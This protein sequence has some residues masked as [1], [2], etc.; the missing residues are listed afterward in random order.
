MLG[1]G[2]LILGAGA[3]LL[4][5]FL[6]VGYALPGTWE[7]RADTIL[8]VS[9]E[10]V[11][12]LLDSPEGWR[13]WTTWP[14][15]GLVRSGPERGGGASVS[16]DDRELGSGTFTVEDVEAA[17]S[18]TYSVEVAGVGGSAMRTSGRISLERVPDGTRV[19]WQERG[20]LGSNPLMG[21]WAR[22]MRRAQSTEM[23][24]G[25][26]RLGAAAAAGKPAAESRGATDSI[27]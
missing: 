5:G 13:A 12:P 19:A 8:T 6:A 27:R 10:E 7:A 9:P 22:S 3:V 2:T 26:A 25:L 20:D 14:D 21:W 24:K 23:A 15:S 11:A 16:W 17:G 18:V 1:P 4:V